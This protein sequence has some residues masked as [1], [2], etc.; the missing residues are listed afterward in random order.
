M[1]G[2]FY[3]LRL[4]EI[5]GLKWKCVD[6]NTNTFR[7]TETLTRDNHGK[8]IT[9]GPKNEASKRIMPMFLGFSEYLK[10]LK[11]KQQKIA[12]FFGK[13]WREDNYVISDE[14]G[15]CLKEGRLRDHVIKVMRKA[16]LRTTRIHD[17]R[18]SNAT[19]LLEFGVLM[20][21]VSAWLGHSSVST[22]EKVYAHVNI[23][24]R[25]NTAGHLDSMF[26]FSN[27]QGRSYQASIEETLKMLFE[28]LKL[29]ANNDGA[30]A[31]TAKKDFE[32]RFE[33]ANDSGEK[34][35]QKPDRK[36]VPFRSSKRN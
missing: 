34:S 31:I 11:K 26:G 13:P 35:L 32:L 22:T 5:R 6:F 18:H 15:E 3:G 10:A 20:Q 25:K 4:G 23:G 17:L 2:A 21:E 9:K 14:K 27:T 16:V 29:H 7:I 36:I 12:E 1:L 24:I 33:P 28:S 8:D 30:L 19:Y